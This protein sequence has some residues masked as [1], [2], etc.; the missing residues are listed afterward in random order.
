M[1][2]VILS[3]LVA[4]FLFLNPA[5]P[6]AGHTQQ[7]SAGYGPGDICSV[8]QDGSADPESE[9]RPHGCCLGLCQ[10][11]SAALPANAFVL[12]LPIEGR[13]ALPGAHEVV[14]HSG[15]GAEANQP[16]APPALLV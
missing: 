14:W 13:V 8:H 3:W 1:G 16:R 2:G 7:L 10:H 5:S 4:L 9:A 11:F 15:H 6:P 12:A